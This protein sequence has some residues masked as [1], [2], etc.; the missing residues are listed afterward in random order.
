[1]HQSGTPALWIVFGA[2]VAIVLAIDLYIG[3][4]SDK[5][6]RKRVALAWTAVWVA[7]GV[8]FGAGVMVFLGQENGLEFYSAYLI[9][10]SLS[11]DNLFVFLLLFH[12]FKVPEGYQ[13]RVLFWGIFGAVLLR[14]AFIFGG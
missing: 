7:I 2:V 11:V 9:E 8:S 3:G 14:A 4:K 1:M 5:P 13:H 12:A 10:Y 6:M